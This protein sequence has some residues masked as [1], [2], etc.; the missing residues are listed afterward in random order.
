M[1]SPPQKG[2]GKGAMFLVAPKLNIFLA[3]D[4][5]AVYENY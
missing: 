3:D 2:H 5:A 4:I 1:P